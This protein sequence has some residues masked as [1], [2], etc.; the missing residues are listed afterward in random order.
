MKLIV[1]EGISGT[2]KTTVAQHVSK[3]LH[4][5]VISKDWYKERA[6]DQLAKKPSLRQWAR[7]DRQSWQPLYGKIAELV[8]TDGTLIVDGDFK[9]EQITKIATIIRDNT[10]VIELYCFARNLTPLKRYIRRSR[11]PGRHSGHRDRIWYGTV[12]AAVIVRKLGI[13]TYGPFALKNNVLGIDTTDFNSISY[14]EI[15]Q[16]IRSV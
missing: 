2:G 5:A 7:I 10:I 13:K 14:K 11:T 15:A 3:E 6:Y 12:L 1:V 8:A 9:R 16:Y 4:C